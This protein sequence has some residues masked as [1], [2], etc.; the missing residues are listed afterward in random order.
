MKTKAELEK[1][2]E[3]LALLRQAIVTEAEDVRQQLRKLYESEPVT[4]SIGDRFQEPRNGDKV[5]LGALF[6]DSSDNV[7]LVRLKN[8]YPWNG[9]FKAKDLAAITQKE[10]GAK[11][12]HLIRYWDNRKKEHVS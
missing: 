11:L 4:Y 9:T 12:G 6:T 1:R 7:A 8:G 2:Q 10:I 3:E 5:I